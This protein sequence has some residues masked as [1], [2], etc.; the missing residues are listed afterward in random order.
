MHKMNKRRMIIVI[1]SR[2]SK[3]NSNLISGIIE[4]AHEFNCDVAIYSMFSDNQNETR[5]QIG[6]EKIFEQIN[7]SHADGVIF[8]DYSFWAP[9]ILN[10]TAHIIKEKC[11][12]PVVC[13]NSTIADSYGFYNLKIS[14]KRNFS[15]I[16]S[17]LIEQHNFE[18]I[19]CLTGIKGSFAADERL[20][21]YLDS[22]HSHGLN[23]PK[24]YIFYG[25]FWT[26]SARDLADGI[27]GGRIPF[28]QAIACANDIM[29]ITLANCLE[30]NGI[31]VPSDIAVTGFDGLS[32]SFLNTPSITT[33][34]PPEKSYGAACVC[35]LI[36]IIKGRHLYTAKIDEGQMI[37][38]DSC[39]C[40]TGNNSFT[41]KN[42]NSIR[43][44]EQLTVR[45]E[46]SN[47]QEELMMASGTD[48]F[49]NCV[50]RFT[51]LIEGYKRYFLCLK[52]SF[53]DELS[54]TKSTYTNDRTIIVLDKV[55]F[56]KVTKNIVFQTDNIFPAISEIHEQPEAFFFTPLHFDD[57]YY[58]FSVISFKDKEKSIDSIYRTWN[59][60]ISNAIH[61]LD[62]RSTAL[63]TETYDSY[64]TKSSVLIPPHWMFILMNEMN[65][66]ENFISGLPEMIKLAHISQEHLTRAFRKYLNITPTQYIN[67]LRLTYAAALLSKSS[68]D[69]TEICFLSGFNNLSHFYHQFKKKYNC[70]PKQYINNI[71]NK[72]AEGN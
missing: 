26:E 6:E 55:E 24:D 2:I 4:K 9:R 58:G 47:M 63:S 57:K 27:A 51:Y 13:I 40:H 53:L 37:Y 41:T 29:A 70:S 19:Y 12:A 68:H 18:K 21:G 65:K 20:A 72:N 36:N 38:N 35:S 56:V 3:H 50:D 59:K 25:D 11:T 62:I 10:K 1:I 49:I 61:I 46:N 48:D 23:V 28:P 8:I 7:F 45:L 64:R 60:Y 16:I 14:E 44:Q 31:S 67:N 54:G 22:M 42:K 43:E 5:H 34:A 32:D 71:K 33:F 30:K 69:I 66:P 39:G 15:K 17:H 52:C